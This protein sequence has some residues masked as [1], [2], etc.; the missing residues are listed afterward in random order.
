MKASEIRDMRLDERQQKLAELKRQLFALRG[1]AVTEN[2]ANRYAIRNV[3]RD[4]AR[5][6]TIIRQ[7]QIKG[8]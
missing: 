3:R 2:M 1:Q 5:I 8:Q 6:Q 7:D 4:I